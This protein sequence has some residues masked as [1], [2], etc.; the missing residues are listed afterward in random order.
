MY[1]R[2]I[3]FNIFFFYKKMVYKLTYLQL[4]SNNALKNINLISVKRYKLSLKR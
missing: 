4:N 3:S 2:F 1:V